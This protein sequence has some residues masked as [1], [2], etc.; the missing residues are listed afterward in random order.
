M[1]VIFL[2][3]DGVLNSNQR[4]FEIGGE[5]LEEEKVK[6]LSVIV[7]RTGAAVVLHSGWRFQFNEKMLPLTRE[8]EELRSLLAKYGVEIRD[9]TPDFSTQEIRKTKKFS[10]VKADEILYWLKNHSSVE[11]YLVLDDLDLHNEQL[12]MRQIRTDSA[13]GLSEKDVSLAVQMLSPASSFLLKEVRYG[14]D[15]C[16]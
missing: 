16:P 2:D 5:S 13:D 15:Q 3:V 9:K 11:N 10:L 4:R 6:L 8:A 1:K 7:R 12:A 14:E